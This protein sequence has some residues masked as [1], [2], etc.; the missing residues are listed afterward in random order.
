MAGQP[1]L[2]R[3]ENWG[4]PAV[5]PQEPIRNNQYSGR[6]AGISNH[7]KRNGVATIPVHREAVI[8]KKLKT[9]DDCVDVWL[10]GKFR[11][12]LIRNLSRAENRRKLSPEISNTQWN[13]EKHSV[14]RM[15]E[16]VRLVGNFLPNKFVDPDLP[17]NRW[18]DAVD[19]CYAALDP[20]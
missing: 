5:I 18:N 15:C 14:K 3:H 6:H 20:E 4:P 1:D 9:L 8:G 10:N 17:R 7:S 19:A 12:V 16:M 2:S 11:G 13:T